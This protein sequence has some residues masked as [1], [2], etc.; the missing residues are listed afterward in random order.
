MYKTVFKNIK[1]KIKLIYIIQLI[2]KIMNK[3]RDVIMIICII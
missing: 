1:N 2:F 3:C